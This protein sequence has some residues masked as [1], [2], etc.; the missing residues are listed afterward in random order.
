[1]L[2]FSILLIDME[3]DKNNLLFSK[4]CP[5]GPYYN[6]RANWTSLPSGQLLI[7]TDCLTHRGFTGLMH[8]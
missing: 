1:M 3:S 2:L 7:E 5:V 4:T 8:N 6:N